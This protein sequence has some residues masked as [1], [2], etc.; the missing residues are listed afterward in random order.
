ML[1]SQPNFD[2]NLVLTCILFSSCSSKVICLAIYILTLVSFIL[3]FY[4][5]VKLGTN[6]EFAISKN[7][8]MLKPVEGKSCV[9]LECLKHCTITRVR[10]IFLSLVI[11]H[12]TIL[13]IY[14]QLL[15]SLT[16][17]APVLRIFM[18]IL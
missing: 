13:V 16:G 7:D 3:G 10:Q 18:H 15:W 8:V 6:Y 11:H 9:V 12:F 1:V 17:L 2:T 14:K 5:L 4:F